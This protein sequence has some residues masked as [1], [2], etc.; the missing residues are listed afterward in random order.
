M[1]C[2]QLPLY[3]IAAQSVLHELFPG[4]ILSTLIHV[5]FSL[6]VDLSL[7]QFPSPLLICR[8]LYLRQVLRVVRLFLQAEDDFMA[9]LKEDSSLAPRSHWKHVKEN[10]NHDDRYHAVR[11]SDRR[12]ELFKKYRSRLA[13]V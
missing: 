11:S 3:F 13:E 1:Y 4:K 7:M 12:E 8:P 10:F 6:A 5:V 9:M 2:P